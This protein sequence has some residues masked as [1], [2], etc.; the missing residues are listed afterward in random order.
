MLNRIDHLNEGNE[1]LE[2][3]DKELKYIEA[4]QNIDI[5]KVDKDII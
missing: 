2:N 5:I 1:T 3:T 4:S